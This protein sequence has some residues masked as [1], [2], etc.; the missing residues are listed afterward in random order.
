MDG[1]YVLIL[2]S[3]PIPGTCKSLKVELKN[4]ALKAQG[5]MQGTYQLSSTV[6]RRPLWTLTLSG[7]DNITIGNSPHPGVELNLGI[8]YLPESK[9]WTLGALK[10]LEKGPFLRGGIVSKNIEFH[11]NPQ[12]ILYWDYYDREYNL[13]KSPNDVNDIILEC[14]DGI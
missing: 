10:D 1:A 9:K 13:Y 11:N 8:L 12:N 6:N 4:N 2:F 7:L 5:L 3:I 14:I